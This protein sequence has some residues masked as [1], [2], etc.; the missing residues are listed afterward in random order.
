MNGLNQHVLR[1]V[2]Q[3]TGVAALAATLALGGLA[4]ARAAT[5]PVS[6]AKP[7]AMPAPPHPQTHL[8]PRADI[9]GHGRADAPMPV[10]GGSYWSGYAVTADAGTNLTKSGATFTVPDVNCSD[11]IIGANG[12]AVLDLWTGID[13]YG[14]DDVEQDGI[15]AWC[16]GPAN[17]SGTAGPYFTAWYDICCTGQGFTSFP[18]QPTL[19][20]GNIVLFSVVWDASLS[21]YKFAYIDRG[22]SSKEIIEYEGCPSG[23]TCGNTTAETIMEDPGGGPPTWLLCYLQEDDTAYDIYVTDA[24]GTQGSLNTNGSLWTSSGPLDMNFT[25]V[26]SPPYVIGDTGT[27]NSAGTS[28]VEST[29]ETYPE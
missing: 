13:G 18:D 25:G 19:H 15:E 21:E 14:T 22:D 1:R 3:L 28:F 2:R 9:G 29:T 10:P 16:T 27:L 6:A 4:S 26:I 7:S 12:Y 24:A 8:F 5:M 20:V 23:T 17:G 11:T